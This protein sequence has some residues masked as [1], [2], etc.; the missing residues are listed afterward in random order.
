MKVR[1]L[2]GGLALLFIVGMP[3]AAHASTLPACS[4]L[5]QEAVVNQGSTFTLSWQSTSTTAG[6]ITGI[7]S[8]G[9]QGSVTISVSKSTEII[10]TFSGPAGTTTCSSS[11]TITGGTSAGQQSVGADS[12]QTLPQ[13]A[14]NAVSA[15]TSNTQGTGLVPCGGPDDPIGCQACNVVDL[16]NGLINFIIEVSIPL[17]MA[18]FAYAGVLY[19]T[20]AMGGTENI[21]KAKSIF[22]NVI[23][24]FVIT[25]GSYLLVETVLHSILSADYWKG[26]NQVVCTTEAQRAGTTASNSKNIS[27]LINE[28]L[29]PAQPITSVTS[30]VTDCGSGTYMD[31]KGKEGCYSSSGQYLG[32]PTVK[33]VSSPGG[34]G[35]V[36]CPSGD[37]ACSVSY[38]Q[39]IGYTSAQ[40]NTMSCI[41][42]TESSGNAYTPNSTTGACGTFQILQS[43]WN[44]S[45]LH[46]GVCSSATSCNDPTCNAQAAYNLSQSRINSGQSP[47][48]DWTC[49]GCNAKAASCVAQYDP[50]N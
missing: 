23:F 26:W 22:R 46:S 4:L 36:Q 43:N 48:S 30:V 44:K 40:A 41:A 28:V 8:V 33:T 20:S 38:L 32:E 7:G 42:M 13:S 39:S 14:S 29:P 18:L 1:V 34:S 3:H 17:A 31:E 16:L 25:L 11:I 27:D 50:G 49:P 15:N 9:P 10:G 24:G 19:F 6:F 2:L 21:S 45:S 47:Y 5:P 35:G 37:S 12:S